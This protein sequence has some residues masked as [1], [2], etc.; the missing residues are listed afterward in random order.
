MSSPTLE[1]A[2]HWVDILESMLSK[3]IVFLKPLE[4]PLEA[5]FVGTFQAKVVGCL[6]D[7]R[8]IYAKVLNS[9]S[10]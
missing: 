7:E 4:D 9:A 10:A 6:N 8:G 3:E 1:E 2:C 5:C